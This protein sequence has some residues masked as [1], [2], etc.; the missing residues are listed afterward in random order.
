MV[1][2]D[3]VQQLRADSG[4][5]RRGA[6]LD[7]AQAQMDV[8]EQAALLC[9]FEDRPSRQLSCAADVVEERRREKQV[10]AQP[11]M[12]LRHLAADRRDADRVLEQAARIAVVAFDG[13]GQS[14]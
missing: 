1:R 4:L 9:R 14:A 6:L 2:A 10:G 8:A 11:G 5:E 13:R 12:E 7:H 3:R